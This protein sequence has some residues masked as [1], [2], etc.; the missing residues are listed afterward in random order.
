[1]LLEPF[2]LA[3]EHF[4]HSRLVMRLDSQ[5]V[6]GICVS[7]CR[8]WWQLRGA[9]RSKIVSVASSFAQ[10]LLRLRDIHF[11]V[12]ATYPI[13]SRSHRRRGS[14]SSVFGGVNDCLAWRLCWRIGGANWRR[15]WLVDNR[16]AIAFRHGC[17]HSCL[18]SDRGPRNTRHW[19]RL[20]GHQSRDV[21]R[22]RH[23]P[24]Q[25]TRRRC[26]LPCEFRE[27]CGFRRLPRLAGVG[28]RCETAKQRRVKTQRLVYS[29][30]HS[31]IAIWVILS[32]KFCVRVPSRSA[33]FRLCARCKAI[34]PHP[35]GNRRRRRREWISAV[36]RGID[37]RDG[38]RAGPAT[39]DRRRRKGRP[40]WTCRRR[41]DRIASRVNPLS[42]RSARRNLPPWQRAIE[43]LAF[44]AISHKPTS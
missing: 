31:G 20:L 12:S 42:R 15:G 26:R 7:V 27:Q 30:R 38:A 9:L 4:A 10:K 11:H 37:D 6:L 25:S 36:F 1:M 18:G 3:I 16:N 24:R 22:R 41:R 39:N 28:E 23:S 2:S 5:F 33:H 35:R 40:R 29:N 17:G 19:R 32:P 13:W 44:R 21:W 14:I 43:T 8:Q 34:A